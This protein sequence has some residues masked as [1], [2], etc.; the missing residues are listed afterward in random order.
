MTITAGSMAAGRHGA[1]SVAESLLIHKH[2][3]EREN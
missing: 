1:G 2:E 3:A